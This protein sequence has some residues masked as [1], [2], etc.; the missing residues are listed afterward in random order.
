MF[1]QIKMVLGAIA[2]GFA[3][4]LWVL[5]NRRTAERDRAIA[6]RDREYQNR[7]SIQTSYEKSDEIREAKNEQ[8]KN[9]TAARNERKSGNSDSDFSGPVD[10]SRLRDTRKD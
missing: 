1:S 9:N 8:V 7:E 4:L 3:L 2:S 6:D 5:F 10:L